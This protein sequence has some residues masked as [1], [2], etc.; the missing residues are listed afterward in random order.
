MGATDISAAGSL[1]R[2]VGRRLAVTLLL[3]GGLTLLMLLHTRAAHA[4]AGLPVAPGDDAAA[5]LPGVR[6]I[7]SHA[8]RSVPA[9]HVPVRPDVPGVTAR[10]R[11]PAGRLPALADLAELDR[12]LRVAGVHPVVDAVTR[13]VDS[14]VGVA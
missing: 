9:V 1:G 11:V 10:V 7:L 2:A 3:T 12:P 6:P 5:A 14:V 13:Q 8:Q 4:A